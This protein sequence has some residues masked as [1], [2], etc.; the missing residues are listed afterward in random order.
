MSEINKSCKRGKLDLLGQSTMIVMVSRT[1]VGRELKINSN[2]T[3]PQNV[4]GSGIRVVF[5]TC[6]IQKQLK[7]M[8]T[9]FSKVSY[10]T[11]RVPM[12]LAVQ[13][14]RHYMLSSVALWGQLWSSI[15]HCCHRVCMV[16]PPSL[17]FSQL[18]KSPPLQLALELRPQKQFK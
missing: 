1:C 4:W 5:P 11:G 14:T 6:L 16:A 8:L 9:W 7:S 18:P 12:T 3:I 17:L 13:V 15:R 10:D 2:S